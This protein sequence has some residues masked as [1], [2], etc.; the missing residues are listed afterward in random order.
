MISFFWKCRVL[1]CKGTSSSSGDRRDKSTLSLQLPT[2]L[3]SF[4]Y[5]TG[6]F[7][8]YY[9]LS[10]FVLDVNKDLLQSFSLSRPFADVTGE[11]SREICLTSK[12]KLFEKLLLLSLFFIGFYLQIV[13]IDIDL[14]HWFWHQNDDGHYKLS[15]FC[16]TQSLAFEASWDDKVLK[17]NLF[18]VMDI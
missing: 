5:H 3:A 11:S 10:P 4:P 15:T 12:R 13:N 17:A 8:V 16:Q 14:D 1:F 2:F 9:T 6:C 18:D 7:L